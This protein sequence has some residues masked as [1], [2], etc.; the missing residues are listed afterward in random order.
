MDILWQHLTLFESYRTFVSPPL[1]S[2]CLEN[3]QIHIL[4]HPINIC[5]LVGTQINIQ[6]INEFHAFLS[7]LPTLL[8]SPEVMYKRMF[9]VNKSLKHITITNIDYIYTLNI[10]MNK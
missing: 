4:P 10:Q 6:L 2:T 9:P 1:T 7:N 3:N 8:Q 5:K